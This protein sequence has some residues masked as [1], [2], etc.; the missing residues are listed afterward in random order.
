MGAQDGFGQPYNVA[1]GGK[2]SIKSLA[3]AVIRLFDGAEEPV[4]TDPRPGDI[5][6]SLADIS[7]ARQVLGYRPS[8]DFE[9]GLKQTVDWYCNGASLE[10]QLR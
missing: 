3:S 8:V 9:S 6:D 7:K 10:T 5:R 2:I 1:C 4:F